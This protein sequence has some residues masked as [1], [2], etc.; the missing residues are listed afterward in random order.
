MPDSAVPVA[1][2]AFQKNA[3]WPGGNLGP[4]V[5]AVAVSINQAKVEVTAQA[6][7]T[8]PTTFLKL[9]G[10]HEL[11]FQRTGTAVPVRR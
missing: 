8:M 1:Q 7:M 2:S 9:V 4:H 5:G 10:I 6:T 3:T 11:H